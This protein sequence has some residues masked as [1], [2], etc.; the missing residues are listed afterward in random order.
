M[1]ARQP[2]NV[3][4]VDGKCGG[5]PC[6]DGTRLDVRAIWSWIETGQD[7]EQIAA[8]YPSI[9]IADVVVCRRLYVEA[10]SFWKDRVREAFGAKCGGPKR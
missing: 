4:C 3:N 10:R 7:D 6:L 9:T 2:G 5:R 8:Q 1:T